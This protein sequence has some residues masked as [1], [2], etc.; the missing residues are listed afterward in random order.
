MAPN[1]IE[2][3]IHNTFFMGLIF[4]T[5]SFVG[6]FAD[7]VLGNI[8]KEKSFVIYLLVGI[9]CAIV[10]P[11]LLLLLSPSIIVLVLAMGAWG[12]YYESIVFSKSNFIHRTL[13]HDKHDVGWTTTTAFMNIAYLIGPSVAVILLNK[14]ENFPLI[15]VIIIQCI[16]LIALGIYKTVFSSHIHNPI[17]QNKSPSIWAGFS[18]WKLLNKKLWPVLL[19]TFSLLLIDS[20]FWTIGAV[21][22]SQQKDAHPLAG[23]FYVFYLLPGLIISPIGIKISRK[24]GKKRAAFSGGLFAGLSFFLILFIKDFNQFIY[25]VGVGSLGTSIAL[26]EIRGAIEDYCERLGGSANSLVGLISS[27]GSLAYIIGPILAGGIAIL[28]GEMNTFALMGLIVFITS[29]LAFI[30]VPR[31]IRLPQNQINEIYSN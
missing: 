23:L 25:L 26:P 13:S 30:L 27:M 19:F 10:F 7:I 8:I 14:N 9:I 3:Y 17:G 15:A 29:A 4:S 12:I 22:V 18:T 31:K 28:I 16:A 11:L 6:Y 20:T 1:I 21:L 2:N 5:S 24:I